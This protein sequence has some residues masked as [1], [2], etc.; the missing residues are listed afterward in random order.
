MP[1][2]PRT[3]QKSSSPTGQDE[4]AQDISTEVERLVHERTQE[5]RKENEALLR[6]NAALQERVEE[7]RGLHRHEYQAQAYLEELTAANE[8]LRLAN[9][10]LHQ[11][12]EVLS[13]QRDELSA[14]R[15]I[16]ETERRRYSDLFDGAP[17]GYLVTDRDGTIREANQAAQ[18]LLAVHRESL[19]SRNLI[20]FVAE[21]SRDE[22]LT[23]LARAAGGRPRQN[24]E[25]QLQ[26]LAREPVHAS[27]SI[28]AVHPEEA[29]VASLRWMVRDIT[30]RKRMEEAVRESGEKYRTLF[31]AI[32]EGFCV[33]EVLFDE[34]DCPVDYRFLETNRAFERQTG[35]KDAVGRRM[36]EIAPE[37]EE[38]WFQ[39]YGKIALTGEPVR[40]E[41]PACALGH[42]YDVYAFRTGDPGQRRVGILFND[43]RK[44]REAEK[45]LRKSEE[46]FRAFVTA[47][48]EVVYRTSPDWREMRHL[49]G[50]EFI[51]DTDSPDSAWIDLYIHPD[52]QPDV[53]EVISEAIRTKSIC[54]L[55]HRV[56]RVDGT[57]GWTHSRAIPILDE[58]GEIVEWFGTASDI[59]ERKQA[60]KERESL[61]HAIENERTLLQTV[62]EQL[63]AGVIIA[64]AP[65]GKIVL[66]NQ[67]MKEIW[68]MPFPHQES[69]L[70]DWD[71]SGFHLDWRPYEIGEW[72][73]S[74]SLTT[75][76][77]VLDEEIEILRGDG[78]QGV[79]QVSSTPVR[80]ACGAIRYGVVVFDDISEQKRVEEALRESEESYRTI[81]ETANEGIWEQDKQHS[82]LRVNPAMAAMLGYRVDEMIGKPLPEFLFEEDM[83]TL[84]AAQQA[85][86][87]HGLRGRYECRLKHRDGTARWVLVSATPQWDRGGNY[88]G[89][90]GVFTDITERKQ[91]E[92][93]LLQ[94]NEQIKLAKRR[95][96]TIIE[97]IPSAVVLVEADG[98]F[99]YVNRRAMELYGLDHVGFDL[100]EHAAKVK[101][102]RPDGT[103]LPLEEMPVRRSLLAG[104]NVRNVEMFIEREDGVRLPLLVSSV[105]LRDAQGTITIAIVIF[106]DITE[107]KQAEE[108]LRRQTEDLTR[109]QSDLEVSNREANL[110]LD[111]LTHDI[112]N[113]ENVSNLYA[114]LLIDSLQ[115]REEEID[116]VH[117]LQRSVQKSIEILK[118][119]STIRRIHRT[120][121]ELRPVDLDAAI[122]E[123]LHHFP[124]STVLYG[125]ADLQV[126]GDDLLSVIFTN[127]IG[128]AVKHGGPGVEIAVQVEEED[129]VVRVSVEDTGPGVPDADKEAIFHRYEQKK[130]GVG[131]GLGL[132]LVQILVERYGGRI[133]AEDRISGRPEEGAVFRFTL[134]KAA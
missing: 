9:E 26:P 17:D 68:G 33:I 49:E 91:A 42:Y 23:R 61:F 1:A 14:A 76:E 25:L 109:L 85:Q 104:E 133:W 36:R 28:A 134:R 18:S 44:R 123:V 116:Y 122:R 120:N 132:Y 73:L 58:N 72:P 77:V 89:S 131:E 117:K 128:N 130:R 54:E 78:T 103:P 90:F 6:E 107:R 97:A 59:T 12:N 69:V 30:D 55:E 39:I 13:A 115:G 52:D 62:L 75:G 71:R 63:P 22:F 92:E 74:R 50:K 80:D 98:T 113:T 83:P 87:Q 101:A 41:N 37:H 99:S 53:L 60:E 47:S 121:L 93:A 111:I 127:L 34:A 56:L 94:A 79:V 7:C 95:L 125:G 100:E 119:V 96:E 38:H 124:D 57:L 81:I 51:P 24:F 16:A 106:D 86:R 46:R 114:D 20:H 2:P 112:G 32:D 35:I 66:T 88:A 27:V 40:F 105:P 110:Y 48:S 126:R 43:I 19:Q 3:T 70:Q 29:D 129:G 108:A 118:A 21:G 65:S 102:L 31:E 67:R 45:A 4:A 64:E 82:T 15:V 11:I 10:E 84:H 8:E 5:I